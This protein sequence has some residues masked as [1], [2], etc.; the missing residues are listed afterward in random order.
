MWQDIPDISCKRLSLVG[1]DW[2][3]SRHTLFMIVLVSKELPLFLMA[4]FWH[5]FVF[6][7]LNIGE[8]MFFVE[9]H[10]QYG[11]DLN[12]TIPFLLPEMP[13]GLIR[14]SGWIKITSKMERK[15][16]GRKNE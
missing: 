7:W 6:L 15:K 1:V 12:G 10:T 8:Q 14:I 5:F 3:K 2:K 16:G 11:M 13:R 9:Y 4:V